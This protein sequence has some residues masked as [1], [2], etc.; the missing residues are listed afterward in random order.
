[1]HDGV[2][3]L[4]LNSASFLAISEFPNLMASYAFHL[5]PTGIL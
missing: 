3:S 2:N 1:M 5:L 4:S